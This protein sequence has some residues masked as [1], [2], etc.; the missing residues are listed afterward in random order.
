MD[1]FDEKD[2]QL[3]RYIWGMP[4]DVVLTKTLKCRT[5]L[6]RKILY[7]HDNFKCIIYLVEKMAFEFLNCLN[8]W[9]YIGIFASILVL[10]L[11]SVAKQCSWKEFFDSIWNFASITLSDAMTFAHNISGINRV[12]VMVWLFANT[13]LLSLFSGQ[14]FEFI[15]NGKIIDR[16]ECKEELTT[17]EY[18]KS[19][20]IYIFDLGIFDFITNGDINNNSVAKNFLT[21]SEATPPMDVIRDDELTREILSGILNDNKV[22]IAN[23]LR[24]Y[25]LV[26]NGQD[27]YPDIF[28]DKVEGIDYYISKPEQSYKAYYSLF[29]REFFPVDLA[30]QFNIM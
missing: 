26:R 28:R 9:V 5:R 25:F 17:K 13:I 27:R 8:V 21:R 30:V 6:N 7:D 16:I 11:L 12:L 18:W 4:G 15:I 19:S 3:S 22:I 2:F 20:K 14:L 10:G 29:A 1:G 24:T 23:K